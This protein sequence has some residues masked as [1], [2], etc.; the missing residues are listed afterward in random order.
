MI[1]VALKDG[2]LHQGR[3]ITRLDFRPITAADLD[4]IAEMDATHAGSVL[5]VVSHFTGAPYEAL[6]FLTIDDFAAA[7]ATLGKLFER[8]TIKVRQ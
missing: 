1:G 6:Q 8:H 2:V 5:R 3:H 7:V 4:M